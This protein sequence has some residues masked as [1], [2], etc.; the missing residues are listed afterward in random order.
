MGQEA[1]GIAAL[2][3]DRWHWVEDAAP[4]YSRVI[5][6]VLFWRVGGPL[7][8]CP[9]VRISRL[10]SSGTM[11]DTSSVRV[12]RLCSTHWSAA[13]VVMSLVHDAR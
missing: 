5:G 10:L 13:M 4:T 3:I 2:E 12:M 9:R 6:C 8:A 7:E 1:S 11:R